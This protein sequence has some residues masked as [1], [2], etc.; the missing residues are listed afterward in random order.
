MI[1][2]EP[3]IPWPPYPP[4]APLT[5]AQV[6]DIDRVAIEQRGYPGIVLMENAGRNAAAVLYGWL[7]PSP[8]AARVLILCGVGN[9]GGDGF[10]IARHLHHAGVATSILIAGAPEKFTADARTNYQI[11]ERAG[12][13]ITW[14]AAGPLPAATLAE[15]NRATL[16]VDALLGTGASG[17]PR[18]AAAELIRRANDRPSNIPGVAIDV[19]S[20]LNADTGEPADPTF[21][22]DA[23]ITMAA[24]KVGFARAAAWVG[25]VV[26]VDIGCA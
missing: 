25:R 2:P 6:R 5:V 4:R 14:C 13:P 17:A 20:G 15:F 7:Q 11:A 26:V 22:A 18:G 24:P 23:T 12:I 3:H 1:L 19:P 10:V 21:R 8:D 16:I 9:N